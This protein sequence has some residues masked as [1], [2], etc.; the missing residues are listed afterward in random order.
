MK[1]DNILEELEE[2]NL[3]VDIARLY[4]ERGL[5]QSD[6]AKKKGIKNQAEVSKKLKQ[7]KKL[8]IVKII[9]KPVFEIDLA[10]EL[11]KRFKHLDEVYISYID[12]YQDSEKDLMQVLGYEGAK[13][14][15]QKVGSNE[16]I[17]LSCGKT[18]NAFVKSIS[19]AQKEL[20]LKA[21]EYCRVYA[22]VHPCIGEIVD[23]TPAS[24]VASAIQQMPNSI[25]YGYQL[26]RAIKDKKSNKTKLS[27]R[28]YET[29]PDVQKLRKEMENLNYYFVGI[30]HFDEDFKTKSKTGVG[31]QFNH[32]V[33]SLGLIEKLKQLQTVG[34]CDFQPYDN[35]GKFL[36]DDENL[37]P[38][39]HNLIFL[40]LEILKKHVQ[41]KTA[42]VVAI[43]GG[44]KKHKAIYSAARAGIFNV[45][46]TDARTAYAICKDFD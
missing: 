9:I 22:L 25:G 2:R 1:N 20:N 8:G 44:L 14:F 11:K 31:L 37:E 36:I 12:Y 26:P 7:A 27:I 3:I 28:E 35:N 34:E 40:P 41:N 38:L 15:A 29:H 18:L 39:R 17:G 30:G 4:Y 19:C 5:T 16:R 43:A 10:A 13:Y 33:A 23:P 46:I 6:I 24:L 32:F 21:K 45:L 42:D